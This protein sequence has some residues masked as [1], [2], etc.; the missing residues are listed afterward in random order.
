MRVGSCSI[1]SSIPVPSFEDILNISS[2]LD[3]IK[4]CICLETLSISTSTESIY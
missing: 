4:L 3:P 2:S 1:S